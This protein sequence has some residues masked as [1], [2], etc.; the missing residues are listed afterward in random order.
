M[1][2]TSKEMTLQWQELRN[3]KPDPEA[4]VIVFR[5]LKEKYMIGS[6]FHAYDGFGGRKDTW[7]S[8]YGSYHDGHEKDLWFAFP[9]LKIEKTIKVKDK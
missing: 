5:W 1:T 9:Q 2:T 7:I 6:Y 3:D 4:K 8:E